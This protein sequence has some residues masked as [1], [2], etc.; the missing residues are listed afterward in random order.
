MNK[1]KFEKFVNYLI[2]I[3]NRVF[4]V[5]KYDK[6][7]SKIQLFDKFLSRNDRKLSQNDRELSR[8]D[9]IFSNT[10]TRT[11]SLTIRKK[12][13]LLKHIY[14][15]VVSLLRELRALRG[16]NILYF[17]YIRYFFEKNLYSNLITSKKTIPI[18]TENSQ[19]WE[20]LTTFS[21]EI[22]ENSQ[23]M[24]IFYQYNERKNRE[25]LILSHAVPL[26]PLRT[27]FQDLYQIFINL[28]KIVLQISII[29]LNYYNK[30]INNHAPFKELHEI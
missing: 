7:L 5:R 30:I 16:Y 6:I 18:K 11:Y 8:N 2:T 24:N 15:V 27:V 26:S 19:H 25:T 28:K 1:I 23:G 13:N 14:I 12:M 20:S 3:V 10:H 29:M 17:G 21:Q 9:T 4:N 22:S